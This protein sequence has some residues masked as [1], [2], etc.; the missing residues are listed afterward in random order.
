MSGEK[1]TERHSTEC[2]ATLTP[3]VEQGRTGITRREILRLALASPIVAAV[4]Q[5]TSGQRKSRQT[6]GRS[7]NDFPGR[8]VA[9]DGSTANQVE[10]IR[11]WRVSLC[12]SELV[13]HGS[14][15]IH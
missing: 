5:I 3:K 2:M 11:R 14:E 1:T 10:L 7:L 9:V 12:T 8:A 4:P 6:K 15:P 13:N